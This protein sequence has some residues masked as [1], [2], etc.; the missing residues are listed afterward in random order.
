VSIA[1]ALQKSG[2]KAQKLDGRKAYK[3]VYKTQLVVA[4]VR[5]EDFQKNKVEPFLHCEWKIVETLAGMNSTS[6]YNEFK[7]NL[8]L[9][10]ANIGDKKKGLAWLLNAF[11]TTGVT[12]EVDDD[13]EKTIQNIKDLL[14]TEFLLRG[15]GWIPDDSETGDEIQIL[16][17]LSEA[18]AQKAIDKEESPF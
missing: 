15:W 12:V 9:E 17:V 13:D 6:Q 8:F 2:Y 5:D 16:Q 7:K 3:G 10:E 14:G 4:E 18:K 11:F 1:A